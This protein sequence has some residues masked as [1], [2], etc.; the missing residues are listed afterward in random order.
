M[1][2]GHIV[3]SFHLLAVISENAAD[4]FARELL[5]PGAGFARTEKGFLYWRTLNE[6]AF[7]LLCFE[8]LEG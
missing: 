2:L 1:P 6:T 3:K 5:T 8:H 7:L 4:L